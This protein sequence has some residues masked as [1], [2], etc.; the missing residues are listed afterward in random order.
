MHAPAFNQGGFFELLFFL[1]LFV[2]ASGEDSE[3]EESDPGRDMHWCGGQELEDAARRHGHE[4]LDEEGE[5]G[6]AHDVPRLE[7]GSER[8]RG[9]SGLIREFGE[10]NDREGRE[11]ERKQSATAGQK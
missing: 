1:L 11:C 3:D 4:R 10:E 9:K 6:S 5:A 7:L 8:H 2:L